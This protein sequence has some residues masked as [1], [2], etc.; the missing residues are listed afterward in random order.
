MTFLLEA[1]GETLFLPFLASRS[2]LHSLAHGPFLH[3]KASTGG[4][5]LSPAAISSVLHLPPPSYIVITIEPP[6]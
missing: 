1:P 4:P 5:D 2:H 3:L 6:G